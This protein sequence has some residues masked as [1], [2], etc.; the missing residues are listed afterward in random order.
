MAGCADATAKTTRRVSELM[1]PL[2][3]ERPLSARRVKGRFVAEWAICI[4]G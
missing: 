2:I 3:A 4:R 1:N